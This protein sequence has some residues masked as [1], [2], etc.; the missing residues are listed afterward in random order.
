MTTAFFVLADYRCDTTQQ[1]RREALDMA[2]GGTGERCDMYRTPCLVAQSG[3]VLGTCG[4]RQRAVLTHTLRGAA[5]DLDPDYFPTK[6]PTRPS[7][8]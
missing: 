6:E 4:H 3:T 5:L 2:W 1:S 7:A 8:W